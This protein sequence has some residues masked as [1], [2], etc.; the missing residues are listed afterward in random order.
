[1]SNY[2]ILGNTVPALHAHIFPR[3][4][5]EP[6]AYRRG[7]VWSYPDSERRGTRFSE[8]RHGALRDALAEHLRRSDGA[9]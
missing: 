7:P 2:E 1:M 6:P 8:Q 9:A 3:Y 5:W 4:A